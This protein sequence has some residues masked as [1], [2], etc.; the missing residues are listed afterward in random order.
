MQNILVKFVSFG[1]L[2]ASLALGSNAFAEKKVEA[3][4]ENIDVTQKNITKDELAAIYV[5]SEI[6]PDLIKTDDAFDAGY[7]RLLKDYLPQEQS[8]LT[9]IKSTVQQ[10]SF[11]DALKQARTDV[12]SAGDQV[13]TQVCNDVKDY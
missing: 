5:L 4:A 6:C 11:K 10:A 12:K 8:P 9:A 13:N 2:S 1:I 3:S 7:A